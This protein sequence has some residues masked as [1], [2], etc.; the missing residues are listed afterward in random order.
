MRPS[1]LKTTALM[2]KQGPC[3]V[4]ERA[5]DN[6]LKEVV[7]AGPRNFDATFLGSA[8]LTSLCSLTEPPGSKS[9]Y[10]V[11]FKGQRL[12]SGPGKICICRHT[13]NSRSHAF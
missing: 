9:Y 1:P 10:L 3:C 8:V 11:S 6:T 12:H 4:Y 13:V 2:H 5:T 7:R